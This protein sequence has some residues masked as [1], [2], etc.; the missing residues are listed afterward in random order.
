MKSFTQNS[1]RTTK[2]LTPDKVHYIVDRERFRTQLLSNPFLFLKGNTSDSACKQTTM[3][4]ILNTTAKSMDNAEKSDTLKDW[5]ALWNH[6]DKDGITRYT[7]S[8]SQHLQTYV[9]SVRLLMQ[10]HTRLE[11]KTLIAHEAVWL[12]NGSLPVL[13]SSL[14]HSFMS[15]NTIISVCHGK[16]V[17]T[18]L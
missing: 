10:E 3:N 11:K 1:D 5:T 7:E 2:W 12:S 17:P 18:H 15:N 4:H 14:I 9:I 8:F 13:S 16:S 6:C